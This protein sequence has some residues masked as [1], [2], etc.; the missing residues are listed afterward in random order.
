M[1]IQSN[2]GKKKI[3]L[4]EFRNLWFEKMNDNYNNFNYD[5][6]W[7]QFQLPGPPLIL[8]CD[9]IV[10]R[11]T[12][13]RVIGASGS[14]SLW[15]KTFLFR[16]LNFQQDCSINRRL[17]LDSMY[18][19]MRSAFPYHLQTFCLTMSRYVLVLFGWRLNSVCYLLSAYT[20]LMFAIWNLNEKY[21]V[22]FS[23][24]F[25][26]SQSVTKNKNRNKY[27]RIKM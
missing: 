24:T 19:S 17:P 5:V 13:P 22:Q 10:G 1:T 23:G 15:R 12:P 8:F 2:L 9:E 20:Y 6:N 4:T 26:W 7:K 27:Q 11:I 3:R 25:E 18:Q 14:E 16:K 21:G